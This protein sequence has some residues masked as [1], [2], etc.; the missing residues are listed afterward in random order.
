ELFVPVNSKKIH[1]YTCGPTVYDASHMG[2][3]RSY[4][5]FDII[6]RVLESYFNYNIMYVM[7]ITDIDD[8]IIKRARQKYRFKKYVEENHTLDQ[9]FQDAIIALEFFSVKMKKDTNPDAKTLENII[10][11]KVND[12]IERLRHMV[13]SNIKTENIEL[14]KE[15][16]LN[17]I[18]DV[19]SDWLD[20]Q[21]KYNINDDSIYFDLPRVW[22]KEFHDDM[23]N[24]NILIPN[25]LTRVTEYIPEIVNFITQIIQNGYAYV[26]NGSV[27]FDTIKF[28]QDPNHHYAK[29]LPEAF[30]DQKVLNEGEGE[31][32]ISE[33]KLS[34]KKSC[35][36]F[37][38]W[39][40]SKLEEPSWYSPWGKGRPGWHIECSVMA[41]SICGSK[42]DIHAGGVDLKF[43]HHDNEIAQSE[44][45]FG[46]DHWVSFFLHS[47]HLTIAGCKMSKSLKNFVTIK[48][49]LKQYTSRQ[50]RL[51]FLLHS[52]KDTL[53]YSPNTMALS[54]HYEKMLNEFFLNMK[55]VLRKAPKDCQTFTKWN[56]HEMLLNNK[57]FETKSK[58]HDHLCDSI[59]TKSCLD[60]VKDLV[61]FT[62]IYLKNVTQNA[63]PNFDI[64]RRICVEI[65]DLFKIFGV[66][67]EEAK[68]GPTF[69][70]NVDSIMNKEDQ[71][72]PYLEVIADFRDCVKTSAIQYKNY[73]I[74]KQCDDLRDNI[75]PNIGVRLEDK[76]GVS[77]IKIIDNQS[78]PEFDQDLITKQAKDVEKLKLKEHKLKKEELLQIP[79]EKLFLKESD[80]YSKFDEKGIPT[81]DI[82]GNVVT[83]SQS[84]KLMKI[85]QQHELKYNENIKKIISSQ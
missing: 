39:K 33:D 22:E 45:Y 42:L 80:K 82:N 68:I 31:L 69:S 67:E 1:W 48:D 70:N 66:Y 78:T 43:P 15:N 20:I 72:L 58:V 2:H 71:I 55:D 6:R 26:S 25:A 11:K 5:S 40:A 51:T 81:H 30:G 77:V 16:F 38:L 57:L 61:N 9:I 49:A 73:E 62:Y 10:I 19:L 3:A 12:G 65:T 28:D 60:D 76:N 4:I 7:N 52:W 75:L 21:H 47:G 17:Q 41:T 46:D 18:S 23:K 35:N 63:G 14:E 50:L 32:S 34:E 83:K 44:A 85:Y 84:K 13:N 37:A 74:L 53:D 64:I 56:G 24:L 8:K 54:L 29:L 59:D 36:D 27:Y 79:P